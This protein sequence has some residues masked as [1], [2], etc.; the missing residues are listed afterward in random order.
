MQMF[1]GNQCG[2]I[3]HHPSVDKASKR[4]TRSR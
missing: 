1:A 3:F 4:A 2:R